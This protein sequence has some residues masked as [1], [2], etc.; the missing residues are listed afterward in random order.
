MNN[1]EKILADFSER[2]LPD[3][4]ERDLRIPMVE[5][6]ADVLIG[7]RRSGKTYAM[8]VLMHRLLKAGVPK[9]RLFYLNLEDDR[10]GQPSLDHLD[11]ALE[12][13]YRQH[14]ESRRH[15]S[16]LFF[17]EI[18]VVEG[19]E[20]FIRRVL[21]SEDVQIVLTGSSAKLLS[22]EVATTLR[23][24]GTAIEVLPY[25]LN[26]TARSR[27][28]TVQS[29]PGS[30]LRSTLSS[31]AREYLQIGGFPEVQQV[32]P[33]HR[34]Q[35]LQ[36]YVDLVVLKDV[37]ERH[38]VTNVT[39]L[40][41]LARALFAANANEFSIRKL[42]G[43]LQSQ[44]VKVTKQTLLTYLDHLADAYLC[45][46]VSIRS[47]SEKQR[48]V[49]PRKVYSVDP[50]L[51]LAMTPAAENRGALLE[52]AVYLELRRRRGR[53]AEQTISYYRTRSGYEVDFAV[54]PLAKEPLQLFQVSASLADPA[55]LAR[56]TRALTEAMNEL[57]LEEATLISLDDQQTLQTQH[58][59]VTVV[60]FWQWSLSAW[61][62]DLSPIPSFSLSP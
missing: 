6:K 54:E 60:P 35:I 32:H 52:N 21:D 39:A 9:E 19:W 27:S 1:I 24:R 61:L 10:L 45:F 62:Q 57:G 25:N 58:K 36:D 44:G 34:T 38:G 37:V 28:I 46:L 41:H 15:R 48:L 49:N 8:F 3:V 17:D 50:G 30:R 12:T 2:P 59:T 42:T 26:E 23:G 56:E 51:A 29:S 5:G 18:Q 20:R 31:L 47:R 22:S 43:T 16:F 4:V 40:R 11:T 7:M 14:P 33:Y 13:F 55:T 53:L